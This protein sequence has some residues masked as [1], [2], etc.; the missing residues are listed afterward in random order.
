VE[1][2]STRLTSTAGLATGIW[3][4]WNIDLSTVSTD[5]TNVTSL[6]IGV[7]GA[8]EGL[9]Y[10][11]EIGLYR[12]FPGLA[13]AEGEDPGTTD[14][15]LKLSMEDNLDDT[16][17]NNR[18]ASIAVEGQDH[19]TTGIEGEA[20]TLDGVQDYATI[21]V[22][23]LVSGLTSST[24]SVWVNLEMDS[25]ANWMRVFDFGA[26]TTSYMFLSPRSGTNGSPE[27]GILSPDSASGV[28]QDVASDM[29]LTEGWHHLAVVIEAP[30]VA[31]ANG[32]LSLYVDGLLKDT[33]ETDTMPEDLGVVPNS[34]LGESQWDGDDLFE[35]LIDELLIYSRALTAGEVRYLAGDR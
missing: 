16:S 28:E 10:F 3:T 31:D 25:E 24:Y 34:M 22:N 18:H 17:G 33:D 8:G 2:N 12:E 19:Y 1:I 20:W 9:I 26:D 35:G 5:L 7:E 13:N 4:E 27:F 6:T 32:T 30:A 23:S 29:A 15:E 21:D 14:L 11:D